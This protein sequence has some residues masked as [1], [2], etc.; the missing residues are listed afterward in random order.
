MKKVISPSTTLFPTRL[1]RRLDMEEDHEVGVAQ[2][3]L[4]EL[5]ITI[6]VHHVSEDM[7][8]QDTD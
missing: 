2:K 1:K 8:C 6:G 5:D 4:R 3:K 7:E